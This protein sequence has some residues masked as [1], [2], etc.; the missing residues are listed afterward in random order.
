LLGSF[1]IIVNFFYTYPAKNF[2]FL[3]RHC[4]NPEKFQ[5]TAGVLSS[6]FCS[7][8]DY[9][10]AISLGKITVAEAIRDELV[11]INEYNARLNAFTTIFENEVPFQL[12]KFDSNK[13]LEDFPL[14]GV[15]LTAKDNIS[16]SG[17]KT[18]AG[19]AILKD[20]VPAQNADV[21]DSA[22]S[23]GCI[24]LGKTNL[25]E[26]AMGATSTSSF[27]GPVRNPID[28]SRIPGGSSG[29]S[30]V[31][32]SKSQLPIVSFGTD[33]GGSVRIPAALCGV[34]GFKPTFGVLSTS[35]VIPLSATLDH[36]GIMTKNMADMRVA[37][38][39]LTNGNE[40][41]EQR[42]KKAGPPTKIKKI[43]I[44]GSYFFEGCL[45]A[46]EKA[47]RKA[48]DAARNLDIA[49]VEDVEIP[50][51]RKINRTR[52][53]V[54]L[55]EMYQF[56][57]DIANDPEKKKQVGKDVLSFFERGSKIGPMELMISSRER[58]SIMAS[59]SAVMD[60]VDFLAMPTCLTTAPKFEEVLGQEAGS[61]RQQ[62]VRN[63]ELFNVCGMPSL[64][65]P[66]N[67][68]D[69]TELPT[70]IEISGRAFEDESVLRAGEMIWER[71]HS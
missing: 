17:Q 26:L 58:I 22:L 54:Q 36:V 11:N 23:A 28:P 56:Y 44:P 4:F 25:H 2:Q 64:S 66:T 29:G 52:L 3:V 38:K 63:T 12:S 48:I 21:I 20:Y 24:L 31:S 46:V 15:P 67:E 61:I 1:K 9:H 18:T 45:P 10:E 39:V 33:T 43:G 35:G 16:I 6:K 60:D 8:R 69:T 42:R 13:K 40:Q 71:M 32:V 59:L 55:W 53:T 41:L 7:I 27:F 30:A 50:D 19:S 37:F 14:Y 65:I 57:L 49:I 62:L 47:F 5:V 51:A 68:L 70:A 34:C